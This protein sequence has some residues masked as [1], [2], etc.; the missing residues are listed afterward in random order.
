VTVAVR[1]A[2]K[3]TGPLQ[4]DDARTAVINFLFARKSGG[5]FLFR[6]DDTDRDHAEKR[7]GRAIAA[8]I[9]WLGLDWDVFARQSDR[10]A[11]YAGA[12][13]R[14]KA[15]G[16][17]Y[18]RFVTE[19]EPP[20][21]RFRLEEAPV[22]WDDLIRGHV[23]RESEISGDPVLVR[24]DDT[25]LSLFASVIDDIEFEITHVIQGDD[26][27]AGTAVQLQIFAALGFPPP[28]FAH[29][30][31]L[32]APLGAERIEALREDGIEPLA[33]DSMLAK[34]GTSDPL[35]PRPRLDDLVAAFDLAKLGGAP[36]R[37]DL[38]ELERL[39][40]ALLHALPY[41]AVAHRLPEGANRDF[42]ETV[43]PSLARFSD[44]ARRW[45]E[46]PHDK[47]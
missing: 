27:L 24:A 16:R 17:L 19:Q 40:A 8:D 42:W 3:P 28:A 5:H 20:D 18:P 43:R 38:A 11:L 13:E 41:E 46:R 7:F 12:A 23:E 21:W 34:L 32:G 25:P 29:F 9:A 37:V 35:E 15:A 2:P 6:L 22:V 30:P 10:L 45:R 4:L 36:A 47:V 1:F 26:H 33:I 14:L 31:L 39:N 44:V